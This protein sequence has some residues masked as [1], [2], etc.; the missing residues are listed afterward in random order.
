MPR[1]VCS[2]PV[3]TY[4]PRFDPTGIEEVISL[5][6]TRWGW[7]PRYTSRKEASGPCPLLCNGGDDR[8]V[9][10]EDGGYWCRQCGSTGWVTDS[11]KPM[12][13]DELTSR[14]LAALERKQAETDER[15]TALERI[16]RRTDQVDRY[17][18]ALN[19]QALV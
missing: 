16:A 8:F 2:N 3:R 1:M 7:E 12:T 18:A 13:V 10:F 11:D 4:A 9:L 6:L 19:E 15:V 14:R 17:H 5:A